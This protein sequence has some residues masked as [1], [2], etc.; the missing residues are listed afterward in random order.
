MVGIPVLPALLI[1]GSCAVSFRPLWYEPQAIDRSRLEQDK[2]DLVNLFDGIGTAL[3]TGRPVTVELD[4]A[5]VNRW[6]A[7]R[8]ELYPERGGVSLGPV[9][10]PTLEFMGR[11]RFRVAGRLGDTWGAVVSA[12][13]RFELTD[14]NFNV[15]LE[16]VHAGALPAP[17][18]LLSRAF[19]PALAEH[20]P[21]VR[22]SPEGGLSVP[23]RGVWP[24]GKRPFRLVAIEA[25]GESLR[26]TLAPTGTAP[27]PEGR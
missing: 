11:N 1:I 25:D 27:A 2:Q 10:D 23:R 5:Q 6:L 9:Q 21:A 20:L 3:N 8:R 18:S 15:R 4:E 7:A 13:G 22:R 26:L 12:T 16:S 14:D 19:G 17:L 24:N